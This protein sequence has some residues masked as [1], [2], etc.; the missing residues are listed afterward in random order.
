[1]IRAEAAEMRAAGAAA[2]TRGVLVDP[3]GN[4]FSV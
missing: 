4:E 2:S 3:Q 1:M